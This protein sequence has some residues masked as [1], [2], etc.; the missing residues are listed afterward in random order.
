MLEKK[1][2]LVAYTKCNA[3]ISRISCTSQLLHYFYRWWASKQQRHII[4]ATVCLAAPRNLLSASPAGCFIYSTNTKTHT[5][6]R[7]DNIANPSFK[8][9][10]VAVVLL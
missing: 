2:L 9:T 5:H 3:P 1:T 7:N 10:G 4:N 8:H 6:F